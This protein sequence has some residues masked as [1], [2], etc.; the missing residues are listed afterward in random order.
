MTGYFPCSLDVDPSATAVPRM[1]MH[2]AHFAGYEV[3]ASWYV[4]ARVL[5][6][7]CWRTAGPRRAGCGAGPRACG[8]LP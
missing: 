5:V 4:V 6:S 8:P 1:N 7:R 3:N 2:K